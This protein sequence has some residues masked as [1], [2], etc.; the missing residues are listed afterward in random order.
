VKWFLFCNSCGYEIPFRNR[1]IHECPSCKSTKIG[2]V[3]YSKSK[4]TETSSGWYTMVLLR[5]FFG[6]IGVI[7]LISG[8]ILILGA[9]GYLSALGNFS[10]LGSM[11]GVSL[12]LGVI[13]VVIG[14]LILVIVTKGEILVYLLLEL[15]GA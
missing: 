5:V 11:V 2:K 6:I 15:L 3:L 12:P 8:I 1:E 10:D 4:G 13:F 7:L 14:L 9:L